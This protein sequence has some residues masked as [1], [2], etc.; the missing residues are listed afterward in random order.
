MGKGRAKQTMGRVTGNKRLQAEGR[1]DHLAGA[2]KQ[3]GGQVGE[4]VKGVGKHV[5]GAL[6]KD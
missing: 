1:R 2:A 5:R 6:K 4:R 3:V